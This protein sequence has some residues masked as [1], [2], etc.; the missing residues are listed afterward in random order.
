VIEDVNAGCTVDPTVLAATSRAQFAASTKPEDISLV[1]DL[2]TRSPRTRRR[3]S[4]TMRR[5][6]ER[7]RRLAEIETHKGWEKSERWSP[8][9]RSCRR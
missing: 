1:H 9:T 4:S 6:I 2:D 3:P 7:A 5:R 8:R